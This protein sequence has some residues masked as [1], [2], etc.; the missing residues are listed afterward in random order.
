VFLLMLSEGLR[1]LVGN[2]IHGVD[3]LIYGLLLVLF[4]IF[5]PEG[6]LGGLLKRTL[7]SRQTLH[8]SSP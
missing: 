7:Q 4:I 1:I 8:T 3:Q 2:D 5:M 6:I